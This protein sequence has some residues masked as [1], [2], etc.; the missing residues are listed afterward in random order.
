[1]P[2]DAIGEKQ[3]DGRGQPG[4]RAIAE[5]GDGGGRPALFRR[6]RVRAVSVDSDVLSCRQEHDQ[7]R[8]GDDRRVRHL[9]I[10]DGEEG[11]GTGH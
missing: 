10:L 6:N 3:S 7:R 9:R 8:K 11:D 1:M 5:I 4:N 2:A